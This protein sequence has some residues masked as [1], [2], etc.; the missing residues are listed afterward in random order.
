MKRTAILFILPYFILNCNKHD[1]DNWNV[2]NWTEG[3]A[4]YTATSA[5]ARSNLLQISARIGDDLRIRI[6]VS[7]FKVDSYQFP[8]PIH[9]FEY[10]DKSGKWFAGAGTVN[11]TA[12]TTGL[13][14]NFSMNLISSTGDSSSTTGTFSNVIV[15][16]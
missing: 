8:L 16:P 7:S 9:V 13:S 1:S 2:F 6:S 4:S 3:N 15:D 14:G 11:I 10:Y 12:N 5:E